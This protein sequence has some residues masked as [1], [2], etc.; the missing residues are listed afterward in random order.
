MIEPLEPR[1]LLSVTLSLNGYLRIT[2][3]DG[4]D[5]V[6]LKVKNET[7]IQPNGDIL[8]PQH[9]IVRM[10]GEQVY[11]VRESKVKRIVGDLLVVLG[12]ARHVTCRDDA[13]LPRRH[14]GVPD[15]RLLEHRAQ[16]EGRAA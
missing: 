11:D 2:G 16:V 8:H 4:D 7:E 9:L 1:R 6:V 15:G 14:Q 12:R 3:T 13:V 10:N 5:V